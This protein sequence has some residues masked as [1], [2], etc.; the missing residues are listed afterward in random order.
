M[1][2]VEGPVIQDPRPDFVKSVWEADILEN[3]DR[4][5]R[6]TKFSWPNIGILF[7]KLELVC[8]IMD[9]DFLE[10]EKQ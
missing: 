9:F 8:Q 7:S 2:N 10:A 6:K 3:I 1:I 4:L 5:A